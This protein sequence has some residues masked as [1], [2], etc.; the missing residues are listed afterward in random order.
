[1]EKFQEM[2]SDDIDQ[3]LKSRILAFEAYHQEE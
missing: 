1:M 2:C 3:K